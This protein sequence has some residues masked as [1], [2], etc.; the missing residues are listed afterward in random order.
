MDESFCMDLHLF[1]VGGS[2]LAKRGTA[3]SFWICMKRCVFV[4]GCWFFCGDFCCCC[5]WMLIVNMLSWIHLSIVELNWDVVSVVGL[6]GQFVVD[7]DRISYSMTVITMTWR[8][9][10]AA[11][12]FHW[13]HRRVVRH[14]RW[15]CWVQRLM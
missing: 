3:I 15:H 7:S 4:F 8:M 13:R 5:C 2:F 10:T 9:T 14:S 1:W 11:I 12:F 6:V